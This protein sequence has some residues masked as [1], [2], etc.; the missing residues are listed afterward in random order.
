MKRGGC[1]VS[2]FLKVPYGTSYGTKKLYDLS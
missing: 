1:E 2:H